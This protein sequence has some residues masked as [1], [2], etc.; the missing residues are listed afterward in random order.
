MGRRKNYQREE[1]LEKALPLFWQRGFADTS[2][3]DL[4]R[5]T[6]VNKSGLYAEFKSKE[7]LFTACLQHYTEALT[8]RA[9]LTREPLGWA[10]VESFLEL[11]QS[12]PMQQ[13]GC[14]VVSSMRE[15]A[16]LPPEAVSLLT[17]NSATLLQLL[18]ENVSAELP[19]APA[20]QIAAMIA[21]FFS[22]L[23]LEHSFAAGEVHQPPIPVFL[24]LLRSL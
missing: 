13:N 15:V 24:R 3:Q 8:T 19:E 11:S 4:E 21:T 9:T 16:L 22:G 1:V 5:A 6:G 12:R 14:F 23:C 18:R 2:V 17:E 7:S 20:D 10:N